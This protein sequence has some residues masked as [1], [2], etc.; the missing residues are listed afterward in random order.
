MEKM[1][2][3]KNVEVSE[4]TIVEALKKH[5]DF[6]TN[7]PIISFADF[8]ES[9]DRVVINLSPEMLEKVKSGYKQ[10]IIDVDGDVPGWNDNYVLSDYYKNQQLVFGGVENG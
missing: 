2:K 9:K 10:L 3:V 7:V 6:K 1:I 4:S 5:V 8:D